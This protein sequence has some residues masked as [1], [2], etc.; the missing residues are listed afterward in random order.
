MLGHWSFVW[1]E[2]REISPGVPDLHYSMGPKETHRIGWLEL[3]AKDKELSKSARI[4]VEPSQHQ[5]IPKWAPLMPIHFLIRVRNTV[6]LIDGTRHRMVS[7]ATTTHDLWA[8]S[9]MSCGDKELAVAL[10]P[11]LDRLTRIVK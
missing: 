7:S 2:D 10:P 5:F 4:T 1:H 11:E 8:M 9:I 6:F 3:K